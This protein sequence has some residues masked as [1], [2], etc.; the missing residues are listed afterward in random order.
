MPFLGPIV[1]GIFFTAYRRLLAT[2]W[3][4]GG[5]RKLE[6]PCRN[7]FYLCCYLSDSMVPS[8]GQKNN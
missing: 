8:Y 4:P 6:E 7:H 2:S 5:Y 3:G 1:G